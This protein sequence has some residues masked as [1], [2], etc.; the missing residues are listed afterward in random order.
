MLARLLTTPL[1]PRRLLPLRLRTVFGVSFARYPSVSALTITLV[2]T[3]TT[4]A[5]A[6]GPIAPH[7]SVEKTSKTSQQ[8]STESASP[9]KKPADDKN[10]T[11]PA[12]GAQNS[13]QQITTPDNATTN[14][15]ATDKTSPTN[16]TANNAAKTN[17]SPFHIFLRTTLA[18]QA[19]AKGIEQDIIDKY[20]LTLKNPLTTSI[21]KDRAQGEFILTF[22]T[23][24]R[25]TVTPDRISRAKQA[26]EKYSELLII[27]SDRYDVPPEIILAFWALESTF[28]ENMGKSPV[29]L[30]LA[31]LAF[32][33]R[34][35]DF[36]ITETINALRI[37]QD[38]HFDDPF[39]RNNFLSSWA[40]AMGQV[41]FMPSTYLQYAVDGD[42]DG[43]KDLWGNPADI[44]FSTAN[45]LHQLGWNSKSS[46]GQMVQL[47]N[48][49][50]YSQLADS[51]PRSFFAWHRA[52]VMT[53]D[54]TPL[55]N[56][57]L[58]QA[59]LVVPMSHLGPA[60]LVE[61][62][63][64]V[65]KK[66]NN[67]N[68]FAL[69]VGILSDTIAGRLDGPP[70]IDEDIA[71]WRGND[72]IA[73][74]KKLVALNYLQL[75]PNTELD[76]VLGP[77]TRAALQSYQSQHDLIP[78]G[79]PDHILFHTL[80]AD[81]QPNPKPNKVDTKPSNSA[82]NKQSETKNKKNKNNNDLKQ[83]ER[84]NSGTDA[85]D[86]SDSESTAGG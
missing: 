4:A 45:F 27:A 81:D 13:K 15:A 71:E 1:L 21:A 59:S 84:D 74:Q 37:I 61:N 9:P 55:P 24:L 57:F 72:I 12:T 36:F 60:F 79:Y 76:G 64:S 53:N 82:K 63:F 17:E 56:Y 78:D 69:S 83:Q 62:N 14:K 8:Q 47:P 25:R 39:L 29:I 23:Y 35:R 68:F 43:K 30:T 77:S 66:W 26:R 75:P 52:G 42:G 73:I 19:R 49:F 32:E 28:G 31:T 20:L 5:H 86:S 44:I 3:T 10:S 40:G 11:T 22:R 51:D 7:H 70:A 46:W 54:G 65:I 67:S 2:L 34:R 50:D 85:S 16:Q 38:G 80:M 6:V 41:Q 18:P 48:S 58:Y 33:G